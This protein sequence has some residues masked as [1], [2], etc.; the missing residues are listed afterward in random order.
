[1]KIGI[2]A[3]W[4]FDGPPSGKVV[5]SNLVTQILKRNNEDDFYILLNQSDRG[6]KF[7]INKENIT[8]I[9]LPNCNNALTNI[10]IVP[11]VDYKYKLDVVLFQNFS[12]PFTKSK[13][14]NYVHD[15]L[16]LDFPKF[17][18][19]AEHLYFWPIK[20][21]SKLSS[22]VIT[23]SQSEKTR[24]LRHRTKTADNISV[25]YH[26]I[27]ENFG[28]KHTLKNKNRIRKKHDLPKQFI[29]YLG[30]LNKRKNIATLIEALALSEEYHLVI[31]GKATNLTPNLER[32]ISSLDLRHRVRFTG[33]LMD[34]DMPV[35]YSLANVFC[36]PSYAEG[37]GLPPLEA[38]ASG[39][40]VVVSNT[41]SMPE[42]CGDAAL[43]FDPKNKFELLDQLN[44][45]FNNQRV[46]KEKQALGIENV[47]R[48]NWSESAKKIERIIKKTVNG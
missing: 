24:F 39:T 48:F 12:S 28:K 25:V 4:F 15:I 2:D 18:T 11:F 20:L 30:R 29:L 38:M 6:K 22:Q 32:L 9:Y 33:Y 3:K 10:F 41:T 17:Y 34:E 43:Y 44:L 8:L 45:L 35:L 1:M 7:P 21:L 37:F 36:F 5:V 27:H 26:G 23:I 19:L 46:Y 13:S 14:I 31:A 47:K 40:P 42:I 16:F